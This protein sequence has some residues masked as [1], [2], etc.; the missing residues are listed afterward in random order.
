[1][2]YLEGGELLGYLEERGHLSENEA[3]ELFTQI[4]DAM[5]YC[6]RQKLIHRDLKLEN[7]MLVK[8]D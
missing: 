8:H 6:H 7:I 2:E 1:M 3:R 5:S 4:M